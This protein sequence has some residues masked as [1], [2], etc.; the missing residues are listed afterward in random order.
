VALERTQKNADRG[1]LLPKIVVEQP[2]D[3]FIPLVLGFD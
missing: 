2:G 3:R 1:K